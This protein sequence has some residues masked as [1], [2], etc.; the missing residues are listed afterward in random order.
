MSTPCRSSEVAGEESAQAVVVFRKRENSDAKTA[1]QRSPA[2]SAGCC[3]E[4][5]FDSL[6]V[7][8]AWTL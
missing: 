2:L 1:P 4:L 5:K 8:D 6:V 7:I 3:P